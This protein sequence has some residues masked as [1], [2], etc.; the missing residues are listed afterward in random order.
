MQPDFDAFRRACPEVD[1]RLVREHVD[2]LGGRYFDSFSPETLYGH[3]RALARLSPEHPVEV[4]VRATRE[5]SVACTV[6]AFD[7]PGEFSL[8]TGVLA[9]QGFDIASGDVFTYGPSAAEAPGRRRRPTPRGG[10]AGDPVKRRRI[11]DHFSGVLDSPLSLTAWTAGLKDTLGDIVRL[12]ERGDREAV[13]TAKQRVNGAVVRRLSGRTTGTSQ[14]LYPV[15]IE[16]ELDQGPFTR[17][18]V[19]SEDTPGFLYALC[20]A[21]SLNGIIIEQ[22]RIRTIAS[23]VEDL[24]DLVDGAHRKIEDPSVLDRI[25]LSVLLTK[26]FTFF[27]E[28][29]PDPYAALC[30]FELLVR[31]ILRLAN[32]DRWLDLLTDPRTLQHLAKL[33]GASDF[34]WEDFIRRQYETLL[35]MLEPHLR[36]RRFSSPCELIP[37]RFEDAAGGDDSLDGQQRVINELKDREIFLIDLDHILHPETDLTFLAERLTC[38]A[39][40]VVATATRLVHR[41]L[42]GRFGVPRTVG[43]LEVHCAVMGLGK[44]G[45]ADLGYASDIELLFVYSDNGRTDG[46]EPVSNAEFF[47]RLA[48]GVNRFIRAKKE[49]IFQVDLR[50]RPY[51]A[52]GPLACSLETF[53]R[54]YGAGGDAH[55]YER[56]ALVRMRVVGGDRTLGARLERLR[57]EMVYSGRPVGI[58]EIRALRERQFEEKTKVGTPNVKFGAGGLV[59]LEYGVQILQVTGG[60]A[61]VG[62]RTPLIRDALSALA[63]EGYLPPDEA[64][65]LTSDYLFLRRLINS[66]RMLRGS[67]RDL[68]LPQADSEEFTHLARRMGYEQVEGLTPAQQLTVDFATCT[69][70]VRTFV[71]RHFGRESLPDPSAGSVVDVILSDDI[72]APVRDGILAKAGFRDIARAFDNLRKLA[73][74]GERSRVFSRLAVLAC[75]MLARKADPGMALNNWERYVHAVPSALFHYRIMLSQPMRMDLLLS[76]FSGSQ[77]LADTLVRNPGFLDWVVSPDILHKVRSREA[78]EEELRAAAESCDS[79]DQWLNQ[80]RRFRRREMLRIGTR[81]IFLRVSLEEVMAELSTLA[82]AVVGAALEQAWSVVGAGGDEQGSGRGLRA[83]LCVM[84]LGKLGGNELNYSSDIDLLGVY[85]SD[86]TTA[87]QDGKRLCARAVERLATDLSAH[88]EEGYVYRVDLRLRPFG[89]AGELVPGASS[90][91]RYYR[92]TASLWEIQ[93]AL[94]MRPIAGNMRLGYDVL[95]RVRDVV[96]T[97]RSGARVAAVVGEMRGAAVERVLRRG[98]APIDVKSG[99]G[100]LRDVE[101]LVQALQLMHA[102]EHPGLVGGNTLETLDA[103]RDAGC[104]PESVGTR[105]KEDYVFLRRTEH[106]LQLLDDRQVHVLPAQARDVEAL[107]RRMLGIDADADRFLAELGERAHRVHDAFTRYLTA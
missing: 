55:A 24:F 38:V 92:D 46:T 104:L 33:L 94:K 1:E 47:D 101:F 48:R 80:L 81:D 61:C 100:G 49:G 51:G 56:L 28:A 18:K 102:G 3:L 62:V 93:A 70:S 59:D 66:M 41:D 19:V 85:D 25:K 78:M 14:V 35:P 82:E 10:T 39:E 6:L 67:A 72:P 71:Q 20:T 17:L 99:F 90:L 79:H 98:T 53:C 7:Y 44:L 4:L 87:A 31:D 73:G 105:L 52:S 23:R 107:A 5:G 103:L 34:L 2:R 83:S 22:V 89:R 68:F 76:L 63:R 27:L 16:V 50:L 84:A 37:G 29:A 106:C 13:S 97:P 9:A 91:V 96:R 58:T 54:Y 95:E 75:D 86:G 26:Q 15:R 32:K 64:Q 77:F 74:G 69:A 40:T 43:G 88:T 21:L 42:A 36:G 12:L 11:I 8:I 30:R 65:R 57:D 60:Q 45:G